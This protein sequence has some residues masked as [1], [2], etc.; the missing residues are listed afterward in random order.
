MLES[1]TMVGRADGSYRTR[2]VGPA[3]FGSSAEKID[4]G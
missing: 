1:R 3:T 2:I 4:A